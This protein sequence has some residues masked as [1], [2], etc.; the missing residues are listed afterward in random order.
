MQVGDIVKILE[1]PL[2][3]LHGQLKASGQRVLIVVEIQGRQLDVEMD[4]DW[5][6]EAVPESVSVS[7]V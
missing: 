3:G 2:A 5:V 6:S 1:G 7:A 4:L